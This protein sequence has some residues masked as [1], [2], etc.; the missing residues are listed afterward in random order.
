MAM[1]RNGFQ[2]PKSVIGKLKKRFQTKSNED[3]FDWQR[4][5]TQE[6]LMANRDEKLPQ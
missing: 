6:D 3:T 1:L 5:A 4:Y 2:D